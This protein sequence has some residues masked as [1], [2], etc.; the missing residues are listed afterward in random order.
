MFICSWEAKEIKCDTAGFNRPLSWEAKGI[1]SDTGEATL[2]RGK[3]I[4][5][6]V[7]HKRY[8]ADKKWQKDQIWR[9]NGKTIRSNSFKKEAKR[10]KLTKFDTAGTRTLNLLLRRQTPG[11]KIGATRTKPER[12][13]TYSPPPLG[14]CPPP[15]IQSRKPAEDQDVQGYP[16]KGSRVIFGN[17]GCIDRVTGC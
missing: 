17:K 7:A 1:K 11:G 5:Y 3:R 8:V 13:P 2:R 10:V 15:K 4:K 14:M 9:W 16:W 12:R 6:D